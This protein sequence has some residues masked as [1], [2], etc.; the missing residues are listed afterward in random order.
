M[1]TPYELYSEYRDLSVDLAD[2]TVVSGLDVHEYRNA[3]L[4]GDLGVSAG[5]DEAFAKLSAA[6]RKN[7]KRTKQGEY[8]ITL[9]EAERNACPLF[10]KIERAKLGPDLQRPFVGKGSPDEIRQ[11]LRLA[12][13]FELA[14][15]YRYSLQAYCD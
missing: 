5:L 15:P 1:S 7:G 6:V 14:E 10:Q 4:S 11:A 9:P 12:V 13:H 2:G 8:L 3:S